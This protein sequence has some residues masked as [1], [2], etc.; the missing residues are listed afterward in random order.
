MAG[1]WTM[2]F[3]L[4]VGT[5]FV[6]TICGSGCATI[7]HGTRQKVEFSSSPAGASARIEPGDVV[8]TTPSSVELER[9]HDYQVRFELQDHRPKTVY[10]DRE[11]AAATYWNLLLGG[12]IGLMI[13]FSNGAG[14]ELVPD[15]VDAV[16]EPLPPNAGQLRRDQSIQHQ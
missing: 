8:L 15:H 14:Y 13:D 4:L 5:T 11:T 3:R 12:L 10:I 1:L 9:R 6:L 16:L 2:S 7:L